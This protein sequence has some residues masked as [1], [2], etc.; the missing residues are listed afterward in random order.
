MK[1]FLDRSILAS[2]LLVTVLVLGACGRSSEPE[3]TAEPPA[4]AATDT[5]APDTPTPV[6]TEPEA[7]EAEPAEDAETAD[8]PEPEQEEVT[9]AE[10]TTPSQEEEAYPPPAET[11]TPASSDEA[12]A[13]YPPPQAASESD[14][15]EPE[16]YPPPVTPTEVTSSIPIVPFVLEKPV[17][18]GA[19]VLRGTGPA[20][21]P[22]LAVNVTLMGEVLG[23]TV[24][25]EDGTF[26]I[27][28]P[29]LEENT[30]VGIALDELEG[31]GLTLEDFRALGFRG[32]GASQVPQVGFVQDSVTVGP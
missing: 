24:I 7:A 32:E 19:T 30:W 16:A 8:T 10:E 26:E 21:V 14:S 28:V 5:A 6:P 12:E 18:A 15:G 31:T 17:A 4:P 2:L 23:A 25:G 3:P 20:N 29:A 27:S 9:E 1:R 13:A 11:P 22:I